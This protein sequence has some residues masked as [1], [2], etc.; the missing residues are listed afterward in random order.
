MYEAQL[1]TTEEKI[2]MLRE[3][4]RQIDEVKDNLEGLSIRTLG[5]ISVD[6]WRGNKYSDYQS[7]ISGLSL[8]VLS[9]S[10]EV[11]RIHD[12]MN[13]ELSRLENEARNLH[14]MI[15]SVVNWINDLCTQIENCFN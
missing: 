11:D 12:D 10:W 1:W 4:V 8:A 2:K 13:M 6:R 5:L 3:A 14:G 15:G 7:E 9:Y